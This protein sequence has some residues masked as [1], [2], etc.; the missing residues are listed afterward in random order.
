MPLEVIMPAL[1]MAQDTGRLVAWLKQPGEAVAEGDVLFEVETDKST[2]EV[3][4]PAAG[5][6]ASVTA[7]AGQDVPVGQT[8][9]I[10][11]TSKPDNPVAQAAVLFEVAATSEEEQPEHLVQ[12]PVLSQPSADGRILASPKAR[13]LALEQ[14]LDLA[15]L[16]E[17]GHPQ[18]FH[19]KDL[20]ALKSLAPQMPAKEGPIGQAQHQIAACISSAAQH[21]FLRWMKEDGGIV[22]PASAIWAAFAAAAWRMAHDS[23]DEVIVEL[24]SLGG[25]SKLFANPD[26]ARLSVQPE[27]DGVLPDLRL[28]DLTGSPITSLNIGPSDCAVLNV[29]GRGE[30]LTLRL[31]FTPQQITGDAALTFLTGFAERLEDPLTHLI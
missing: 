5:F 20:E 24:T 2:M 18:P 27:T 3:E 15:L 4:A 8:I 13:R 1:G 17:A 25:T 16:V 31:D 9:A 14:G 6:L 28:Q 30:E 11:S 26:R 22:I 12:R 21:E 10:I 19:V 7:E 23:R 29:A